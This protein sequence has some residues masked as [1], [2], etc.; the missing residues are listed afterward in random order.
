MSALSR[1][2]YAAAIKGH[3]IP[4]LHKVEVCFPVLGPV[5]GGQGPGHSGHCSV[6]GSEPGPSL[7]AHLPECDPQ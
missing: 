5:R 3:T 7:G 2:Q 6:G 4:F 1:L